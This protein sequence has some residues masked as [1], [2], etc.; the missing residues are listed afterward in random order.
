MRQI[1][2]SSLVGV[3]TFGMTGFSWSAEPNTK[4]GDYP[5]RPI[6]VLV[7]YP[8]GGST[9][10]AARIVISQMSI[11]LQQQVLVQNV[12]GSG[13]RTA[14]LRAQRAHPD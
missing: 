12:I 6:T 7:P 5:N 2:V 9:D 14:V 11:V 4:E 10:T 13:G 3:L 8:A 1:V